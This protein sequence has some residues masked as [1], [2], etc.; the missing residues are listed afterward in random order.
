MMDPKEE[1]CK[2]LEEHD[3]VCHRNF[4]TDSLYP[5]IFEI[6]KNGDLSKPLVIFGMRHNDVLAY[7][8]YAFAHY[9]LVKWLHNRNGQL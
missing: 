5:V 3:L 8:K 1:F 6:Y 9:N 7:N 4:N 2:I